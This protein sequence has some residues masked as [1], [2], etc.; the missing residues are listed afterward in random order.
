MPTALGLVAWALFGPNRDVVRW[1]DFPVG[2]PAR[3][4]GTVLQGPGWA[5]TDLSSSACQA[6]SCYGW[7]FQPALSS[8]FEPS[9]DGKV[10]LVIMASG[11]GAQIDFGMDNYAKAF[12]QA[13]LA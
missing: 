2:G 10:P 6:A 9:A 11:L 12:A 8:A 1:A 5:R 7:Y 3:V 13:G 4:N